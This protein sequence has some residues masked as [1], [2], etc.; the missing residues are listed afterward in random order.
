MQVK[1]EDIKE[2]IISSARR[3]FLENGYEKASLRVIAE[4]EGLTKGAVYSYFK[5][6]DALFCELT[7]PAISFIKSEF[8]HDKCD[9]VSKTKDAMLDAYEITI[10][11]FKRFAQAVLDNHESFKLL[12]FCS[13]GSSLQ[14]YK[15]KINQIYAQNFYKLLS[16]FTG[17]ESCDESVINEM[18]VHTLATAY[19]SFLEEVVLHEPERKEVDAYAEQ[20]A[21]F[22]HSGIERLYDYQMQR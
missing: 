1:K 12:L 6:K 10:Q 9:Y 20:M 15:E 4:K 17:I 19:V 11:C 7:A 22:V 2:K 21:I 8:Q 5:N 16:Y 14:N 3:E 18:F 13:A